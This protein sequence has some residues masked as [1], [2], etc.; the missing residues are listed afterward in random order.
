MNS[1][2]LTKAAKKLEDGQ[3]ITIVFRS[4]LTESLGNFGVYFIPNTSSAKASEIQEVELQN[5]S[6]VIHLNNQNYGAVWI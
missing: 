3:E 6:L 4:A 1:S 2:E 5:G